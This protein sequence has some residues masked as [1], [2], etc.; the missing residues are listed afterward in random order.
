[1]TT[2]ATPEREPG[3]AG[4]GS[5]ASA[6][7]LAEPTAKTTALLAEAANKSAIMWID[8]PGD[9]S[10]AVWY[11]WDQDRFYVV[12]GEGEQLLPPLPEVVH[13]ILRSKDSGGRLLTVTATAHLLAP[14]TESWQQ[15]TEALAGERLNATDDVV[16][17]WA[18][19]GSVYALHPFGPPL[20]GPSSQP[21]ESGRAP[22]VPGPATTLGR[23]PWHAGRA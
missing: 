5:A 16:T 7:T 13:L 3:A 11:A 20:S 2:D 9:R 21:Q 23:R 19:A 22:L 6:E 1:M 14:H 15:A 17:R 12:C 18:A 8:I 4:D 10:F